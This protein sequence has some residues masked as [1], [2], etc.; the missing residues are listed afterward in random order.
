MI[1]PALT[2]FAALRKVVDKKNLQ[3]DKGK[4]NQKVITS[5]VYNSLHHKRMPT[6]DRGTYLLFIFPLVSGINGL[7]ETLNNLVSEIQGYAGDISILVRSKFEDDF[8][9]IIDGS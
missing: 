7:L 4:Q 3:I 1:A 6:Y 5:R 2:E 8:R 9:H